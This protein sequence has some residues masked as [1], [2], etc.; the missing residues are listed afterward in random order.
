ML[1]SRVCSD[2]PVSLL[3]LPETGRWAS[4]L[5]PMQPRRFTGS[6]GCSLAFP[7]IDIYVH[8][9]T[10]FTICLDRQWEVTEYG[11]EASTRIFSRTEFSD[12]GRSGLPYFLSYNSQISQFRCLPTFFNFWNKFE[13]AITG[14][15]WTIGQLIPAYRML[16]RLNIIRYWEYKIHFL[17]SS[18]Y[19]QC[20]AILNKIAN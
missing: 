12:F 1:C 3:L 11:D 15:Y 6:V 5:H 14:Q 7:S 16:N 8:T 19:V 2:A 9:F 13:Q 17:S 18:G 4:C 20:N 10:T